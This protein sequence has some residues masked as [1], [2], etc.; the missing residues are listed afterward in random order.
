MYV[1]IIPP[2]R[3]GYYLLVTTPSI[4]MGARGIG[5]SG[6]HPVCYMRNVAITT[7]KL[8]CASENREQDRHMGLEGLARLALQLGGG[9][10]VRV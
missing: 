6:I 8:L 7:V 9:G 4:P 5:P 10:V 2:D 1:S 3:R